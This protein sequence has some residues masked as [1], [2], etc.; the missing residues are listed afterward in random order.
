MNLR[1]KMLSCFF[2]GMMALSL[3]PQ[4]SPPPSGESSSKHH[5][6]L[7]KQAAPSLDPGSITDGIYRNASFGFSYK[8][9]FGWVDRT[10][11]M[12]DDSPDSAKDP[13]EVRGAAGDVRATAGSAERCY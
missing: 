8:L 4:Q 9:L 5:P 13:G 12:Q 3:W 11:E 2:M 1:L 6:K 7:P 10:N